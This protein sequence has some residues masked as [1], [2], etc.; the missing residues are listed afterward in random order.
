M[1][2][3][4]DGFA[5]AQAGIV[6]DQ[7]SGLAE[8]QNV[9]AF[10]LPMFDESLGDLLDVEILFNTSWSFSSTFRS[11]DPRGRTQGTG[12]PGTSTND[13]R[14]R[15]AIP[16]RWTTKTLSSASRRWSTTTASAM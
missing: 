12:G 6:D 4:S 11:T 1:V 3:D 14:V 13:L 7:L 8:R 5:F 10:F 16:K 9:K 15:L 2:S